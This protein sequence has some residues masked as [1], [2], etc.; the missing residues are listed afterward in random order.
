MMEFY[1]A[2]A[3]AYDDIF[4][5]SPAQ[6]AFVLKHLD[7]PTDSS[8]IE[9]GCAAGSLSIE[10]AQSCAHVCGIDID[11]K[12]LNIA[13]KKNALRDGR[14]Q[15]READMLEVRSYCDPDSLDAVVSFGN[16]IV[17]LPGTQQMLTL[18]CGI[19]DALKDSS[20]FLMQIIHYDR[21]LDDHVESLPVIE[22]DS[23]R[24]ERFYRYLGDEHLIEFNT[25]LTDRHR[26]EVS[27]Q[28]VKL[29]PLRKD[30]LQHLLEKSGFTDISWY[31]GFDFSELTPES[32]PLVVSAR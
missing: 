22:R 9:L 12:L 10:L 27:R 7:N 14:A 8:I 2:I 5:F 15:F 25:V 6:K 29:Y 32:I 19:R 21:I 13:E 20:P 17:H 26:C 30:E 1:D 23:I 3:H 18:F 31:G 24:F 11:R 28:S 16:T 4:P